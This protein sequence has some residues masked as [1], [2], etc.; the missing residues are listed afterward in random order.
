ME[1]I[2]KARIPRTL[3]KQTQL[4]HVVREPK[5]RAAGQPEPPRPHRRR[6]RALRDDAGP[7]PGHPR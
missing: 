3:P 4:P 5:R 2:P 6:E 7:E 1:N